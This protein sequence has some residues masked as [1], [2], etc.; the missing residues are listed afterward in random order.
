MSR[1]V[2]MLLCWQAAR[3]ASVEIPEDVCSEGQDC[4]TSD[5]PITAAHSLLGLSAKHGEMDV[6]E[7]G[8]LV[9]GK[10]SAYATDMCEC[11]YTLFSE[12]NDCTG[13][14][15]QIMHPDPD[16]IYN[17][18][19]ISKIQ[20]SVDSIMINKPL[21][22]LMLAEDGEGFHQQYLANQTDQC[23]NLHGTMRDVKPEGYHVWI[24]NETYEVPCNPP[25]NTTYTTTDPPCTW[26]ATGNCSWKGPAEPWRDEPD[27]NA[28]IPGCEIGRA[29]V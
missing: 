8:A 29:H 4:G 11:Q 13:D 19:Y 1:L 12:S 28:A 21:C 24:Q 26:R 6:D 2:L 10:N 22:W 9:S 27:C 7:P 17:G 16:T 15:V 14:N 25:I 18:E 20:K 3:G 5:R 23:F